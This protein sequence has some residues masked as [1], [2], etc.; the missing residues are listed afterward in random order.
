MQFEQASRPAGRAQSVALMAI[1]VIGAAARCTH[2]FSHAPMPDEAFTFF[3]AS[4]PLPQIVTL[5]QTGDF[6]PPFVYLIGHALF[7]FTTKAYL[8]RLVSAAFGVLGIFGAYAVARYV[9]PRWA[10]LVALFV[11]VCPSLVFFDRFFRMYALLWPLCWLSWAALLWSL[12]NPRAKL[13]WLGYAL[14]LVLLLYTHYLALFTIAAQIL[15]VAIFHRK[16]VGFWPALAGAV[17]AFCPWLPVLARQ[18]PL[19]GSAYSELRGHMSQMFLAPA[20]MLIDEVPRGIEYSVV[21]SCVLWLL[22]GAGLF[23]ALRRRQ[24][25][26][27]ALA[28]PILLQVL[29]SVFSGKLLLGQR[30]LLQGIPAALMFITLCIAWLCSTRARVAGLAVAAALFVLM[31]FGTVD[32]LFVSSYQP[33]DWTT[34]GHFLD[35]KMQPGDAIVF[36]G[37]MAY[38]TLVGSRAVS[39]QRVFLVAGPAELP[40]LVKKADVYPRV[41]YVDYQSH[42]PDPN[43]LVFEGLARTHP[44]QTTW[45]TTQA[46]YGDVVLTTLFERVG[47]KRGP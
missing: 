38:Y 39:S 44:V 34:Y 37:A 2:L 12:D 45:R 20:V 43:H 8:F 31:L 6:H 32:E 35:G 19:G 16:I 21:T 14:I 22:V 26:L 36:D 28:L 30:Y 24:W 46:G 47:A 3:I 11:A 4:H 29:Y 18:Y 25:I 40:A 9:V 33:V 17:L 5:L 41:W 23:V 42:L 15:F 10:L 1:L 7:H 27:F 13:R